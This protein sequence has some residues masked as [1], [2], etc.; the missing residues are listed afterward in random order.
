MTTIA[1]QPFSAKEQRQATGAKFGPFELK[2]YD[3]LG[4]AYKL[5]VIFLSTLVFTTI[6]AGIGYFGIAKVEREGNR[7]GAIA[8]A[9]AVTAQFNIDVVQAQLHA[10]RFNVAGD[11]A[12]LRRARQAFKQAQQ[13]LAAASAMPQLGTGERAGR[14]AALGGTLQTFGDAL[15][16]LSSRRSGEAGSDI[17]RRGEVLSSTAGALKGSLDAE[18]VTLRQDINAFAYWTRLAIIVALVVMVANA[19]TAAHRVRH[20]ISARIKRMTSAMLRLADG[21]KDLIVPDI[22]RVDEFGDMA[23]SLE[24]FRRGYLKLDALRAEQAGQQREKEELRAQQAALLLELA[25]QFE[26]TVGDVVG[27][28]AAASTQLQLTASSMAS[29]AEHSA[30]QAT[31]V[32]TALSEASGG[33]TAAAAAVTPPE[34]SLRAVET[35]VA[36]SAECSAAEAIELAVSWS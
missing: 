35:S 34:A 4:I 6:V 27:G 29:A 10:E 16:A 17:T 1:A 20:D 21:E 31:E 12:E 30:L 22:D 5:L 11:A 9:A 25:D 13:D 19:L 26:R 32:S 8:A 15:E 24:T 2:Q 33:V 14:I 3:R 7:G 36:C 23:R 18:L 28:V